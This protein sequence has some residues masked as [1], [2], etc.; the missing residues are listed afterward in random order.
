[1]TIK[2]PVTLRIQLFLRLVFTPSEEGVSQCTR[3][4]YQ[5]SHWSMCAV[6]A[7][8]WPRGWEGEMWWSWSR[9]ETLTPVSSEFGYISVVLVTLWTLPVWLLCNLWSLLVIISANC[10]CLCF[11][12]F[13]LVRV[14]CFFMLRILID[15]KWI[16]HTQYSSIC[17]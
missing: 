14:T 5:A 13:T 6:L 16:L 10:W 4:S 12:T 3:D 15:N 9:T 2:L 7:S 8:D 1:M 11:G 17:L